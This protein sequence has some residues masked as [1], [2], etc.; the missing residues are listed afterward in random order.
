MVPN[1]EVE[2]PAD[3]ALQVMRVVEALEELDDVQAVYYTLRISD[4]V[5]A[6]LEEA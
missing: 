5:L 2:L 3:E 1:N 6:H 4:D